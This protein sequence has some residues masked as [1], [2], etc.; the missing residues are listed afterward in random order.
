M[1]LV[2]GSWVKENVRS[3]DEQRIKA[4]IDVLDLE[5]PDL[6]KW[7]T[8][9]EQPPEAVNANPVF[10]SVRTKVMHNLDKHAA[11][12]TRASPGQPWIR[13]WDDKRGEHG[14]VYGNQ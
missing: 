5:N 7:L 2:L 4:L 3:M 13:G 8:G 6:W 10:N 11:A 1:D 14:P 12:A 9:Q